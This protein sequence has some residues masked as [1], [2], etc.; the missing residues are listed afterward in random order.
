V[1][2]GAFG[3]PHAETHATVLPYVTA[4]NSPAA[5]EAERRLAEAFG[6]ETG[7]GG[8]DALRRDLDAPVAL[9]DHGFAEADIPRAAELILPAV[10]PSNPR[11]V[12]VTDLERLL[13][14]AWAGTPP[15]SF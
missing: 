10:P 6:S 8:L 7:L 5:P 15:E 3:L 11:P 12:S 2:G 4:F 1:L 9:R 14:A 13:K